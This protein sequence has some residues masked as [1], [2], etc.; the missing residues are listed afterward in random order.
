M[1]RDLDLIR[2]MTLLIVDTPT[3]Y[4]PDDLAVDGFTED[5]IGYHAYLMVD[6]ERLRIE[7]ISRA[8]ARF[9][10]RSASRSD[11]NCNSGLS[12]GKTDWI[13]SSWVASTQ[14]A[15]IGGTPSFFCRRSQDGQKHLTIMASSRLS[16]SFQFPLSD[17][18]RSRF[19]SACQES[20]TIARAEYPFTGRG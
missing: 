3:A 4:A 14:K 18:N 19:T 5:E 6:Y 10:Q 9:S 17:P 16:K 11:S 15:S 2:K 1:K 8:R 20:P 12:I 13:A 7:D